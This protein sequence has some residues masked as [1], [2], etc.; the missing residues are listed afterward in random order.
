MLAP[1]F[2]T[3]LAESRGNWALVRRLL[4]EHA[5][6]HWKRY[7][8]AL[9]AMAVAA[10]ATALSAYLLG[11]V[12]NAAYLER[13]MPAIIF[14]ALV[15]ML[16]FAIK[17]VTTY[18]GQVTMARIGNAI[19]SRNQRDLFQALLRQNLEFYSNR[20]SSEFA[21]RLTTGAAAATQAINLLAVSLGRD[22]LTLIGLVAVMVRQDLTLSLICFVIM[23]PVLFS[24]RKLVRRIFAVVRNRFT[25]G[26]RILEL[27]QETVQGV[28]VVK[29]YT[30]ED[31]LQAKADALVGEFERE[32]NKLARITSR[33][34]PLLEGFAGIMIALGLVY[35]GYRIIETDLTPGQFFSFLAALMLAYEPA[36]RLARL[37]IELNAALVGVRVLFEVVDAPATEPNDDE[38]TELKV[39]VGRIA[40][41]DV[42]FAYRSGETV[43]NRMSFAAE[44]GWMTALVGPSGSGKSTIFNLILRFYDVRS[45]SIAIDG[46]AL[47]DVSR[48]SLRRQ[49]AYV[50]QD[51]ILFHGTVRDN[52]ALGK[53]GATDDEIVAAAKAAHAHEFIAGFPDGYNTAVGERGTQLSGGER[54]RIAI[55]RALVKNAK[56]I[57]LD[58]ATASLDSESERLVQDAMEHL[59]R[60]RTTIVIAHRLHTIMHAD[61][62]LV[63]EGGTI[64]ESGRH[65]ELLRRSGRY[66]AFFRL[67]VNEQWPE[68]VSVASA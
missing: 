63:I 51:V 65:E 27:M 38:K 31:S 36:K 17:A 56:I 5:A 29:A 25:G 40:F 39:S 16:L 9:A 67:Q 50:S 53:P 55:A 62:I 59:C 26:A 61:R 23:P 66:A 8:M 43:I 14:Y 6:I 57:L 58:E 54:Q 35:G 10:A 11:D 64:V 15:V 1:K 3:A 30:L 32:S 34:S 48:R 22:A 7:A 33:A 60:G 41:D 47:V 28:R 21:A 2:Q 42:S 44:P 20:H 45:G 68:P 37:N 13:N 18:A 52:I 4:V 46:Q 24:M 12:V 19:V 49:I